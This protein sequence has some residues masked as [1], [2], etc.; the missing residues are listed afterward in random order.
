M[1]TR[2]CPLRRPSGREDPGPRHCTCTL[3]A[4]RVQS[5]PPPPEQRSLTASRV[6]L[7]KQVVGQ[8]RRV[9]QALHGGVEEAGVAEVVQPRAHTVDAPPAQRQPLHGEEHLLG[10]GDAVTAALVRALAAW[11]GRDGREEAV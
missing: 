5:A 11:R 9:G 3:T 7:G 8:G 2:V 1:S 6:L 4:M 10:R